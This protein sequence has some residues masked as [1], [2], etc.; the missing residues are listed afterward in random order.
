MIGSL[1]SGLSGLMGYQNAVDVTGNNIANQQTIGFKYSRTAF[2]SLFTERRYRLQNQ[3]LAN[4]EQPLRGST[5]RPGMGTNL[6]SIDTIMTPG[7]IENTGVF[8]DVAIGGNGFFFVGPNKGVESAALSGR[9][10]ASKVGNFEKNVFPDIIQTSTGLSLYGFLGKDDGNGNIVIDDIPTE[11]DMLQATQ[12]E[13]G[14]FLNRLEPISLEQLQTISAK[15]T[16]AVNLSGNIDAQVGPS[17]LLR[18]EQTDNLGNQ[19]VIQL[20]TSRDFSMLDSELGNEYEEYE[21]KINVKDIQG[22]DIQGFSPDTKRIVFS[23]SGDLMTT[24]GAILNNLRIELAEG[25]EINLKKEDLL[26][27]LNYSSPKITSYTDIYSDK[28][29]KDRVPFLFE[30]IETNQW[31]LKPE[32]PSSGNIQKIFL[33]GPDGE[34]DLEASGG[35][36][37]TFDTSGNVTSAQIYDSTGEPLEDM[38]TLV[39]TYTDGTSLEIGFDATNLKESALTSNVSV[40][41]DGGR[42]SGYLTN[43]EFSMDGYLLGNY[44]NQ[45]QLKLAFI[46]L[47]RFRSSEALKS[48][49]TDP[50]LYEISRNNVG[51]PDT[52]FYGYFKPGQG[53]SGN[54]V[55]YALEISNVDISKEMVNLIKYQRAIQLNARTVQ[56]A[57]QILQQ[58][59]QLKG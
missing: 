55:P 8:S 54:L 32:F 11:A 51:I 22:N 25:N 41:Q 39:F 36:G 16:D 58:A 3:L 13:K 37:L 44:S 28:G 15:K 38:E 42:S 12:V 33:K 49:S 2:S 59:V 30:K 14:E 26:A 56:T 5:G 45:V 52:N 35:I 9:L 7:M 19:Y 20:E 48:T 17:K 24:E 40:N 43:V 29:F 31:R 1:Y 23:P 21:L 47:A 10:Y 46:P 53:M 6:S 50:L 4:D 57:D 27:N 34:Y 18:F